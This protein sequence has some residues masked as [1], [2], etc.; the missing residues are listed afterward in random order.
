[1]WSFPVGSSQAGLCVRDRKEG[2][3]GAGVKWKSGR[4]GSCPKDKTRGQPGQPASLSS[5]PMGT[6]PY[7]PSVWGLRCW[8]DRE[9]VPLGLVP[10]MRSGS[11]PWPPGRIGRAPRDGAGPLGR[12]LPAPGFLRATGV[13]SWLGRFLP[14]LPR[15]L[16]TPLQ[17]DGDAVAGPPGRGSGAW[18]LGRP[19]RGWPRGAGIALCPYCP[20]EGHWAG[21]QGCALLVTG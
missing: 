12:L 5:P 9:L 2:R 17:G 18:G 15:C 1:M 8:D 6:S 14:R 10:L 11:H 4:V 7:S 19:C 16:L 21:Q 13:G 20:R 3:A